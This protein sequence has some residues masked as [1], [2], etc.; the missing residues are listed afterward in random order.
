MN[1][2]MK[3]L[4][5]FLLGLVLGGALF[6]TGMHF[7]RHHWK[8]DPSRMNREH[9][10]KKMLE[11]LSKELGLSADQKVQV[12]KIF[13]SKMVKIKDLREKVRPQ[14]EAVRKAI[15]AEI[16]AVLTPEQQVKF[17]VLVKQFEEHR[18]GPE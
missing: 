6:Y 5:S 8:G 10:P 9:D 4:I 2:K 15:D 1:E 7:C 12:E 16:R 3:F 14:F 17:E 18:K 11:K 13:E